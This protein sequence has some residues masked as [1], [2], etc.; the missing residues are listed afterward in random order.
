MLP[1]LLLVQVTEVVEPPI[2]KVT[3]RL[4][5]YLMTNHSECPVVV[6]VVEP[7]RA[8]LIRV[9]GIKYPV[10]LL[11]AAVV[12]TVTKT[13]IGKPTTMVAELV[14][15]PAV[16]AAVVMATMAVVLVPLA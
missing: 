12:V 10:V 8:V 2:R 13:L 5:I 6:A 3:M 14:R 1:V 7:M 15:V 16:V 11:M 4:V 9:F